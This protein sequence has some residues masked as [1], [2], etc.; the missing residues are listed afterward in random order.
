MA[1]AS[2][3]NSTAIG[4]NTSA[5][6]TN[7][8]ALGNG[9][10]VAAGHTNSTALGSGATTT[11]A[12]QVTVGGSGSSVRIGD[13]DASTAAQTGTLS[14]LTIDANGTL[15]RGAGP[16]LSG[17][18]AAQSSLASTQ[19]AQGLQIDA[20]FDLADV[21]RRDVRRAT[22]GVAMALAMETPMLPPGTT[23]AIGGGIGYYNHRIAGTAAFSARVGNNG[24]FSAGVGIS[25]DSGEFGER[26]PS[27]V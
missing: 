19:A 9:A 7:S 6:A 16:D 25:F 21:N 27:A 2:G 20:L 17:I 22:E 13:I 1:N 10:T 14:F 5:L 26:P 11:A 24:A 18:L 23:F 15:G 3:N 4:T 12:N 8:T